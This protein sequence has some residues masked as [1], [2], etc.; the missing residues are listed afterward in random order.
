MSVYET[1]SEKQKASRRRGSN[2]WAAKNRAYVKGLRDECVKKLKDWFDELKA[3]YCCIVC[4][5]NDPRCLDF[6]HRNP[7]DKKHTIAYMSAR[8]YSKKNILE[9]IDKCDVFCANCH[10]KKHKLKTK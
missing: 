9:E 6:H 2:R 8:G 4:G 5:E 10:R 1:Y 3:T 7:V